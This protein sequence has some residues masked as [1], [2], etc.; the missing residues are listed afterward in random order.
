MGLTVNPA[1]RASAAEL[2]GGSREMTDLRALI[3]QIAGSSAAVLIRGETG[4]GKELVARAIHGESHR[5]TEPFVAVNCAAITESLIDSE[6]FGH[7]KGAFTGA[8]SAHRGLFEAA[9]GGTIF[10]DE[11]GDMPLSTQ[12]RLL[13]VLQEEEIRPVGSTLTR[14]IDVRIIAATNA[15][16]ERAVRH[17]KFRQ[18]LYYRLTVIRISVPSLR[19][20]HGDVAALAS[21]FLEASHY[22]GGIEPS[23]LEALDTYNWPGNVRELGNA[24][25][26]ARTMACGD[27][28][29]LEH[30]PAQVCA[31]HAR[32]AG[33]PDAELAVDLSL[34]YA[35][36]RTRFMRTFEERYLRGMLDAAGGNLSE[37]ARRAGVD[38]SNLRRMLHRH[39]IATTTT[40]ARA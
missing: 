6:L 3:T 4:T 26:Y 17:D 20:R 23:A 25:E 28:I 37:A 31:K 14:K 29:A 19:E 7:E 35:E 32:L 12:A 40:E 30:L 36:A 15:D 27:P 13:R 33:R 21:H 18:D 39:Q 22:T 9:N 2:I 10:L 38:R 11:I 5:H 24:L 8:D 1:T 34:T 16:L